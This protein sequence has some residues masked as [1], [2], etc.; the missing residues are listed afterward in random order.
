MRAADFGSFSVSAANEAAIALAIP[1]PWGYNE[2]KRKAG[3]A[4]NFKKK[5]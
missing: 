2:E 4:W 3:I 5:R 1:L